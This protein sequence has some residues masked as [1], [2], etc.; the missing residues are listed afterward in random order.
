MEEK[1]Q[2][3]SFLQQGKNL[4]SFSWD[5]INHIL[6]DENK[7]LFVSDEVYQE[8]YSICKSCDKFDATQE[9]CTECGCYIP[10]KAQ[11]ILDSCPLQKWS[12]DYKTWE[13]KFPAIE[14]RMGLSN[15]SE[16]TEKNSD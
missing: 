4:A 1:N 6:H 8:R 7:T 9:R 5:L 16:V 15:I 10:G 3:P 12:A 11:I 14:S 13:E 2:Y